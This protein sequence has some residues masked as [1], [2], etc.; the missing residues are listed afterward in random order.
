MKYSVAR[1]LIA[2]LGVVSAACAALADSVTF[3]GYI[4]SKAEEST[5]VFA[6]RTIAALSEC[7][8]SGIM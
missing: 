6:K 4:A 3:N 7:E 8:F 5:F 1:S 2:L